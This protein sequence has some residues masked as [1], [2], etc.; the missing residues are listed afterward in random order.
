MLNA[1][2]VGNVVH[3]IALR[4]IQEIVPARRSRIEI[5]MKEG[6]S[7]FCDSISF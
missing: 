6:T 3:I 5:V 7:I 2:D 1:H 4:D